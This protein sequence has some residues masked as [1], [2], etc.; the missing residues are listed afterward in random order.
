MVGIQSIHD[1]RFKALRSVMATSQCRTHYRICLPETQDTE[2]D[3]RLARA[4]TDFKRLW[5]GYMG[6]KY[7]RW[8]RMDLEG[9]QRLVQLRVNSQVGQEVQKAIE[10]GQEPIH[11]SR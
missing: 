2:E 6:R 8:V 7:A 4:S 3:A 11:I 1:G 5:K 9:R 10:V